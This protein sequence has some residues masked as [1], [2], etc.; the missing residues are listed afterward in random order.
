MV[1]LPCVSSATAAFTS[2]SGPFVYEFS[3]F[4]V[5]GAGFAHRFLKAWMTPMMMLAT[6]ATASPARSIP[7]S[8]PVIMLIICI[9]LL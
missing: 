3:D 1:V 6:T 8:V 7:Y 9:P 4:L 5:E 2:S